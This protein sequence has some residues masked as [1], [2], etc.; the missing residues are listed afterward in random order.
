MISVLLIFLAD[1]ALGGIVGC[2]IGYIK[3]R[4][5]IVIPRPPG[6]PHSERDTTAVT[7]REP[8]IP[9]TILITKTGGSFHDVREL[10]GEEARANETLARCEHC[11]PSRHSD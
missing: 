5:V 2:L 4:K 1:A 11:F 10:R 7:N 8:R 3:H 6:P 9:T